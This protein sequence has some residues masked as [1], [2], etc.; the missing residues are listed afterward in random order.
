MNKP[1]HNDAHN[2][3]LAVYSLVLLA[4]FITFSV[5]RTADAQFASPTCVPPT[6]SPVVIQNTAANATPQ[7]ASIN[8]SGTIKS[9][10]CI[11]ATY[12]HLST[13]Q[14]G[15]RGSYQAANAVC[16]AGEHVCGVGEILESIRCG[17]ALPASGNNGW[18][19]GGPPGYTANA[20]DCAGWTDGTGA[21]YGRVW[22][23]NGAAGGLGTQTPCD[24]SLPFA[25]C[26]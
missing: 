26:K 20:N 16:G 14:D 2:V 11:G 9:G 7:T 6:C 25:C 1:W 22:A 3:R 21:A 8:V 19:N 4:S 18:I 15:G 24:A 10:S 23:F 17:V 5:V 13:A 12:D